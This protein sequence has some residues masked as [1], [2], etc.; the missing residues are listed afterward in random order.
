MKFT[1]LFVL[2]FLLTS[3]LASAWILDVGDIL[4][5]GNYEY[6]ITTPIDINTLEVTQGEIY[7]NGDAYC[8]SSFKKYIISARSCRSSGSGTTIV[9]EEEEPLNITINRAQ[10]NL[11]EEQSSTDEPI[12]QQEETTPPKNDDVPKQETATETKLDAKSDFE[13]RPIYIITT[14]ILIGALISFFKVKKEG[15]EVEVN[16]TGENKK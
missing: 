15:V 5:D 8:S 1:Y 7:I 11:P 10:D 4:Y 3:S 6:S 13:I 9:K 2:I 12:E 16:T 14:V